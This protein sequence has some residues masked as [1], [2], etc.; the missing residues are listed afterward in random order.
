MRTKG[1]LSAGLALTAIAV[2]IVLQ[3]SP[4]TAV[5]SNGV[6]PESELGVVVKP[7][8]ICQ[9]G[10][11]LP[12]DISAIRLSIV[13]STG[14]RV[15]VTASSNGHVITGGT[16]GAGWYGS[17]VTVPV[18]QLS[19]AYSGVKVCANFGSLVG[20]VGVLGEPSRGQ[21]GVTFLRSGNTS[22]WSLAGSVIHHMTLGRATS[23]TWIV[24]AII[25]LMGTAI[26]LASLAVTSELR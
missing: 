25:A 26:A 23:G 5:T 12:R 4:L 11:R 9:G 6:R 3:H 21:M 20:D 2:F 24:F 18:R 17:A 16:V 13:A 10:E 19:R 7:G 14:P 22:W 8:A 1:T 15:N